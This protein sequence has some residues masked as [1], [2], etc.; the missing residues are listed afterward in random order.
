MSKTKIQININLEK[1][2]F[3]LIQ[4]EYKEFKYKLKV[5]TSNYLCSHSLHI[6]KSNFKYLINMKFLKE[7]YQQIKTDLTFHKL[8]R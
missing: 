6:A 7:T 5:F 2:F 1:Y 3:K 8:R 4:F